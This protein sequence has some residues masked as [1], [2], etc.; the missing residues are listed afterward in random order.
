MKFIWVTVVQADCCGL[1]CIHVMPGYYV[2][3]AS[4]SIQAAMPKSG[5]AVLSAAGAAAVA[6]VAVA[7]I[8]CSQ[9]GR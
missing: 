3:H 4:F 2:L 7:V 8:S 5:V 9:S 1:N 6:A